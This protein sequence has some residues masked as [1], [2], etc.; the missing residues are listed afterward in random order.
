[1]VLAMFYE[2]QIMKLFIVN[3][4]LTVSLFF[5]GI[6]WFKAEDIWLS[7]VQSPA[8]VNCKLHRSEVNLIL[9]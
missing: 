2:K 1:M 9:N 4:F 6:H 3:I 5:T 7:P 8:Q